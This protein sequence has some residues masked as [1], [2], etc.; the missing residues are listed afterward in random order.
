MVMFYRADLFQKYSIPVPTTW[1]EYSDAAAKLHAANASD[2]IADFPPKQPGQFAGLAWQAGARWFTVNGTSWKISINDA[3]TLKVAN[4]WQGLINN[5][6][7]K[8][9]PDFTD[10]WYHD[11]QTGSVATW[12][13]G[14]WGSGIISANAAASSG[15]WRVAPLPQWQAGQNDAG[16]WGGSLTVAFKNTQHAQEATTFA[17][18][19]AG[20]TTSEDLEIKGAGAYP[21]LNASLN[22]TELN[23]PQAFY[24]NQDLNDVIKVVAAHIDV[25][26]S[27]GPTMDQVY[28]DMGNGFTD[29]I[30]GKQTLSD[31][32]NATQQSTTTYMQKQ[33]YSVQQ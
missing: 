21:A 13:A 22:S 33:G 9:E 6:V 25:N 23:S 16:N 26:F 8:T 14:S 18:W 15:D 11:L 7:V 29:A 4:Y 12:L 30:N 3:A 32:V 28:T 20:D 17:R 10:A 2:Y 27:W 1:A 31:A 19:I 24:G 5:K